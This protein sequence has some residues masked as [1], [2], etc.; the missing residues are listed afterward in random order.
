MNIRLGVEAWGLSSDQFFTGMGQYAARL[1]RLL[2]RFDPQVSIFAYAGP[3]ESRPDWLPTR[4]SWRPVRTHVPGKLAALYSRL[5]VLPSLVQQDRLDIFHTPALHVLPRFPP[6]PRLRCPVVVTVHDL[7]P[8]TFYGKGA[9]HRR[10]M[11]FYRW[12]LGRALRADALITGSEHIR[13]QLVSTAGIEPE[14]ISVIYDPVE[15]LPNTDSEPVDRVGLDHH[16]YVLYAGSFEPRKN[17]DRALAAYAR[18]APDIPHHLLAVVERNPERAAAVKALAK[19]LK[20]GPRLH[21]VD[22][23]AEPDLRSLYTHADALFFPSLAEGFGFPP[24]QAAA[25]AV[26]VLTSNIQPLREVLQESAL[27]VDPLN[28]EA[29]AEGLRRIICDHEL[30]SR[31]KASGPLRAALYQGK[32]A[33][34]R[35]L[36]LFQ[37]VLGRQSRSLAASR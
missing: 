17:F 6:V 24:V 30:R 36:E 9:L 11:A 18:V 35:H 28:V 8:L 27:Y 5:R 32:Q 22:S 4:V 7:I 2:D 15:F 26:P 12:N 21:L 3:G 29:L 10:T 14:R 33:A 23:L 16:P 19:K 20:V 37:Q 1:F 34:L 31:L 13:D 25:C